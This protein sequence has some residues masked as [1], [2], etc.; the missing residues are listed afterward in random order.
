MTVESARAESADVLVPEAEPELSLMVVRD[1]IFSA[2]MISFD[3][4]LQSVGDT[5][6]ANV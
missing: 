4:I 6:A 2:P 1:S 3:D 5:S